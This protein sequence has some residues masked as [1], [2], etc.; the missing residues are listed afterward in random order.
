MNDTVL[1]KFA[2]TLS[3]TSSTTIGLQDWKND[4]EAFTDYRA[5][6]QDFVGQT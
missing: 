3:A 6:Y 4:I 5:P 2:A 1:I